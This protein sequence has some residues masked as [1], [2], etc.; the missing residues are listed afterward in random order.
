M[1]LLFTIDELQLVIDIFE[2]HS[3]QLMNEIAHTESSEFKHKLQN[4]QLFLD[5]LEN[6]LIRHELQLSVDELDVLSTELEQCDRELLL[7]AA[8]TNHRDL[9]HSLQ[10]RERLL[11]GVRDKVVEACAMA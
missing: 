2:Q 1:Q 5:E 6:K 10:D 7:E 11:Q 4:R 3:R 8:R 9:K